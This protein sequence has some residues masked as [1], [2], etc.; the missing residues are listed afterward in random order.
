MLKRLQKIRI[1]IIE[2]WNKSIGDMNFLIKIRYKNHAINEHHPSFSHLYNYIKPLS[3]K[4]VYTITGKENFII[5]VSND[6]IKRETSNVKKGFIEIE[7]FEKI[8]N[9]LLNENQ[10]SRDEINHLYPKRASAFIASVFAE[11]DFI[12][13]SGRP[14]KL[15]LIKT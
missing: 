15:S 2:K 6:G 11:V 14:A 3:G 7:I 4:T 10:I 8:Y 1:K 13:Y 12:S 5:E 9:V